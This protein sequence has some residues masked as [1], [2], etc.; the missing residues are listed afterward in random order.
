MIFNFKYL[1]DTAEACVPY[2]VTYY[3]PMHKWE[4]KKKFAWFP[5]R[6]YEYEERK[7]PVAKSLMVPDDYRLFVGTK[8]I[9]WLEEYIE[10]KAYPRMETNLKPP[11]RYYLYAVDE[12][13]QLTHLM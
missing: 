4:E 1:I 9:I 6:L 2:P 3:E 7:S 10:I 12:Y 5:H 13:H 11:N 8:K